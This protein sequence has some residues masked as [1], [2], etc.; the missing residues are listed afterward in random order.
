MKGRIFEI[1]RFAVHDGDGIRTAVYLKGC[2]LKCV[3]CHN[4]EGIAG[5]AQMAFL[6]HKCTGCG[7]CAQV[8]ACHRIE[9]GRHLF[10]RSACITCGRCETVCPAEALKI[11]G[12]EYSVE[13]VLSV[14]LEDK[15]FYETSGGGITLSGGE[16][17]LQADF[18]RELLKQCKEQGLHTAVDTC[19]N[20][21]WENVEKVLPY[22]DVFLYDV[23]AMDEDVHVRC[24]G[25]SNERILENLEKIDKAGKSI[26]IRFPYVPEYNS[27]QTEK[28]GAFL[29]QL[30]NVTKVRVL[31]YHD[32]ARSKYHSLQM[33]DTMPEKVP[34]AREVE[35][36]REVLRKYG[37]VCL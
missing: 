28:I 32:M 14:L 6:S 4:P 22:T 2:S 30:Q 18:C 1:K 19:G 10:D 17:L 21:P 29:S 15:V 25:A 16:C 24:T 12:K 9:E 8:C 20:V 7:A 5:K 27:D 13:E 33:P 36:A 35:E 26:E 31:A 3:W 11:Y 34:E 23:K 37:L